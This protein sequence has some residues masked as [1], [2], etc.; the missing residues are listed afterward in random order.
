MTTLGADDATLNLRQQPPAVILLAGLQG[1]GKTT[2]AAKLAVYL[3]ENQKKKTMLVSL[4]TRRPAAMQQLETLAEAVGADF[5][6]FNDG[7]QPASI[8]ARAIAEARVRQS[9]VLILD[10]AGRTR[11]DQE[12]LD[13]LT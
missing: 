11:L 8:A 1:A 2:T 6:P 4:D 9:D 3:K 12:L 13:E 7:E 5:M 10:T